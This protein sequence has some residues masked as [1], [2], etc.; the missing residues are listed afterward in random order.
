MNKRC[1][2]KAK[3]KAAAAKAQRMVL[4]HY[5]DGPPANLGVRDEWY[6]DSKA[7]RLYQWR[8]KAWIDP[9]EPTVRYRPIEDFNGKHMRKLR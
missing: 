3:T 8:G 6:F 9:H 1:R 2:K 5:G 4:M 7:K